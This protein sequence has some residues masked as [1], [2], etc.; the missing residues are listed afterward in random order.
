MT[1]KKTFDPY[2]SIVTSG[3]N[4]LHCGSFVTRLN[5]TLRVFDYQSK[6]YKFDL[7]YIIVEW[8]PYPNNDLLSVLYKPSSVNL[9]V[10]IITVSNEL[11]L[12][13]PPTKFDALKADEITFFQGIAQNVGIRRANGKFILATNGD[14]IL[15]HEMI[16]FFDT[17][18]LHNDS[19]YRAPRF[20]ST[21]SIPPTMHVSEIVSLLNRTS[22]IH[23][24]DIQ[25]IRLIYTKAA[26]DF[27]L[28]SKHLF[29]EVCGFPEIRCDGLRIDGDILQSMG[30]TK[31]QAIITPPMKVY[32]QFH[33]NR[34]SSAYN[35]GN[36]VRNNPK[37]KVTI[38]P[39]D[40]SSSLKTVTTVI[41]SNS[42]NWG[43][44]DIQL[45]ETIL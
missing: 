35:Y 13:V 16:R 4:D 12:Q 45:P 21:T 5:N 2:I 39:I 6:F 25:D 15:N 28:A 30:R 3:R 9:R 20:D 40:D 11:H 27:I 29:H 42:N 22:V 26:G 32:H 17:R 23:G 31:S 33:E 34:Y 8:N 18:R 44:R 19:F 38:E 43:L 10:K 36:H 24:G 41:S 1:I 37:S 7:E 14:I